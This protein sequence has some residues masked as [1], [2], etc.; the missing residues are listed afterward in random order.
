[1]RSSLSMSTNWHEW[2]EA[3][4]RTDSPL[5]MRLAVVRQCVRDALD[6]APPGPIAVISMCAGQ[7]RDLLGVLA[8]HPRAADVHGRLVELDPGLAEIAR[9]TAPPKIDVLVADAGI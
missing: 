9:A 3:Y 2:H 7:G 4:D 8:D 5:A 6:A 1:M